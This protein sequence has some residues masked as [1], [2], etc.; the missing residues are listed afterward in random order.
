MA[1]LSV[2]DLAPVPPH[3][4]RLEDRGFIGA[5]SGSF[6]VNLY[7]SVIA[8]VAVL[9]PRGGSEQMPPMFI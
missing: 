4:S 6:G 1:I 8:E 3:V 2:A 7:C 5:E 9:S